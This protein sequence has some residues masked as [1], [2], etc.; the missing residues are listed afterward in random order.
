ME[1]LIISSNG[2][3]L[4]N[5]IKGLIS[6]VRIGRFYNRKPLLHWP[7]NVLMGCDFKD[8]FDYK[9]KEINEDELKRLLE[10]KHS[11]YREW[12]DNLKVKERII[13]FQ[14][15]RFTMLPK[16]IPRKFAR[17]YPTIKGNNIDF[18]FK[19]IP[20]NI[21][22][23]ILKELKELKINKKIK[24]RVED[25]N[26]K[27]HISDMI[28]IHN[29]ATD[30][31]NSPDGRGKI[32]TT[33][34]FFKRIKEILKEKPKVKFFLCTDSKE[35]EELYKKE[36]GKKIFTFPKKNW[37]MSSFEASLDA[38]TDLLLLSKTKIILG[39]YLSTFT[40]MAWWFGECKSK[41]EIIGDEKI[42][43][44]KKVIE[45]L[46]KEDRGFKVLI[47]RLIILKEKI[48]DIF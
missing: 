44:K 46:N 33:D 29:R 7:K 45:F 24:E 6:I 17:V 9:I 30:F 12:L 4:G 28:G 10:E 37:D 14:C 34:L 20:R 8:L 13:L 22:E 35:T 1:K 5:R 15:W 18:E 25:F 2:G 26:K 39:T 47:K 48:K 31:Q 43:E 19:R 40:E 32:S 38:L 42:E 11:F 27:N 41:I 36:F 23:I 21:R 3:G 16:E